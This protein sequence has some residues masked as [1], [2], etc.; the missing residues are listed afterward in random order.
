MQKKLGK[1]KTGCV[2]KGGHG[3]MDYSGT[4]VSQEGGTFQG[5]GGEASQETI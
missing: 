1:L 2:Y 5:P 3:V 4:A